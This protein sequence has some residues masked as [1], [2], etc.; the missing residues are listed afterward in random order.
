MPWRANLLAQLDHPA[1]E[2]DAGDHG[3]AAALMPGTVMPQECPR[4]GLITVGEQHWRVLHIP[5]N[6]A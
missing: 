2:C 4:R 5:L 1:L 6:V 3:A